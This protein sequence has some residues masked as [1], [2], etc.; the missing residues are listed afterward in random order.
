M[1]I[2]WFLKVWEVGL[3][4]SVYNQSAAASRQ[5]SKPSQSQLQIPI[6]RQSLMCH[7]EAGCNVLR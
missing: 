6:Q 3:D 5:M 2:N 7:P 4:L 1:K